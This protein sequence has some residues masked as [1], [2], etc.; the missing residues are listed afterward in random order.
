MD[1]G[2]LATVAS[3]LVALLFRVFSLQEQLR[4]T[5]GYLEDISE[6]MR[7]VC[8]KHGGDQQ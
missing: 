5:N 6:R 7:E 2:L 3:L 8:D 1:S 4:K